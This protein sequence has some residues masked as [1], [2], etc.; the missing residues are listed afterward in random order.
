MYYDSMPIDLMV[1]VVF[2]RDFFEWVSGGGRG[3]VFV[4]DTW[5]RISGG[6]RA[7]EICR[8]LVFREIREGERR[9]GTLGSG[10][11]EGRRDMS[12]SR[13]SGDTGGREKGGE[14]GGGEAGR[15]GERKEE[16]EGGRGEGMN[17]WREIGMQ[18]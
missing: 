11:E 18:K 7:G 12:I 9:R 4:R 6:G 10:Y 5:E 8:F 16:R 17:K 13:V 2:V 15:E 1:G 14:E 3:F